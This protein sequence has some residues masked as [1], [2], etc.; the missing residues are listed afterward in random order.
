MNTVNF[1]K[2]QPAC[3]TA[4]EKNDRLVEDIAARLNLMRTLLYLLKANTPAGKTAAVL[5]CLCCSDNAFQKGGNK[6]I[7]H[8][9]GDDLA[10]LVGLSEDELQESLDYLQRQGVISYKAKNKTGAGLSRF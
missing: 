8:I 3:K 10:Q 6:K 9:D 2:Q 5:L 7:K 1:K 4:Q